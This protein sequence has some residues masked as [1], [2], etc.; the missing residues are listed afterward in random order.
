MNNM[1]NK[2]FIAIL[3]VLLAFAV[4]ALCSC[5]KNDEGGRTSDDGGE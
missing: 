2:R 5:S 4:F 3:A 1:N